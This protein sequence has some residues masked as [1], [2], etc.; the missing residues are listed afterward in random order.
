VTE[1]DLPA[2]V[3]AMLEPSFYPDAPEPVE[4]VETH[5]SWVLLAGP[6][7]YKV[8][9][10]VRFPFLD[11][12]TEE[13]RH[14]LAREEL[15]LGRRLAP[16]VYRGVRAVVERPEGGFALAGE[17]ADG[18]VEHL[19]E[20]R[21][22][23][24]SRT[25]AALL[26]R[27]AAGPDELRAVARRLAEFHAAAERAPAGVSDAAGVAAVVDANFTT[28]LPF[29]E[30]LGARRLAA[31]HRFAAA[32]VHG[33]RRQLDERAA[34]GFVRDGH[35][36]L[37]AEHVLLD[38]GVEVV[39]PVE[40]D[41]ALRLIDVCADLAFLVMELHAA[42]EEDLA[43]TLVGEYTR[44]G[45]DAGGDEL[46]FFYAAY[47]AWVRCKVACV[48]SLELP[49]GPERK[50]KLRQGVELAELAERLACRARHPLV[51]VVCGR[52]ASG[53][54]TLAAELAARSALPLQSSDVVR[55]ELAG[56]E[57]H[58]RAEPGAYS[59]EASLRTYRE[60][61]ERAAATGSAIVDATFRRRS[62]REAFA[63]AEPE[64][65]FVECIAPEPVLL[66]RAA[67][68]ERDPA[69]VSD[70]DAKIVA[71]QASE[72][73][74]LDEIAAD[75]V[76]VLRTDRAVEECA[77]AVAAWLDERLASGRY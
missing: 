4:L 34:N 58:T 13:R 39:D 47:R 76:L 55:K 27:G 48:R 66:E 5:I 46:L 54:S 59:E 35:G 12:G 18:A 64:A 19:V 25:L 49:P 77:D 43:E 17:N 33:R 60:L 40:F 50:A 61:G 26:A 36:D 38:D 2:V 71:R 42:G 7:A 72:L 31:A 32:F 8:R 11:Y 51:L 73:E 62:H 23:D 14:E 45:G 15:R 75:R 56:I 22:F 69:R 24:P 21:R 63:A 30:T 57:A 53:K 70:A 68:R 9:K 28:L 16:G 41:P 65:L 10:P 37:R 29:A 3:Q 44:A 74:P 6:A 52:A 20:M 1:T 67:A